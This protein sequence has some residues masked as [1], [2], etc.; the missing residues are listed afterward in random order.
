MKNTIAFL[1][2]FLPI[3][4]LAQKNHTLLM[5]Q[6][7]QAQMNVHNFS[8]A[9]LVMQH[10]KIILEKGYGQADKEWN[11]ANTTQGKFEI[12][13]MTK[14]FTAACILQL[15][16]RGKLHFDDKLSRFYPL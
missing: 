10:N 12:G 15:I 5:D 11:I 1:I 16:E 4:A 8:G 3:L 2:I 6:Y 7:L 9:V 14:Q 13:S